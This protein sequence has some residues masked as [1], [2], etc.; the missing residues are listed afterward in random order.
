[1]PRPTNPRAKASPA[2]HPLTRAA[3]ISA[4]AAGA[5]FLEENAFA[6]D[7]QVYFS[8]SRDGKPAA[9]QRKPFAAY[10]LV[11]AL[12]E[13]A[14]A[15]GDDAMRERALGLFERVLGWIRTPG[16]LGRPVLDGSPA[17]DQLNVPMITLNV[18]MELAEFGDT[19]LSTF[20]PREQ[21]WA[22]AEI[23][24]HVI[25]DPASGCI[26]AVL[27]GVTPDGKADYSHVDGRVINPGH[28]IEAGWFLLAWAQAN[29]ATPLAEGTAGAAALP[30]PA[31]LEHAALEVMAWAFEF[32]W[33]SCNPDAE[34]KPAAAGGLL[35]F[36]DAEA[37]TP[38]Q[39]EHDMK[40]WWPANEAMIGC[41]MAYRLT[42]EAVWMERFDRV[43]SWA[44]G[45]LCDRTHGE[46]FGYCSRDGAVTHRFKGGAY[47]GCFHVPRCL[48]MCQRLLMPTTGDAAA[49]EVKKA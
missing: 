18:I 8:L 40:L 1:L 47:K 39:L 35:Y 44:Y 38:P 3:L 49:V 22:V 27:E 46:W 9:L 36:K 26:T 41:A 29:K 10:F 19:D 28:V 25:R 30:T 5:A 2:S 43:A 15:T 42:S 34:L 23:L 31:A 48:L 12:N 45:H 21:A 6:P 4:A 33:D 24:K 32:G 16:S 20:Y 7:G 13:V 37:W 17:L 11:M 14:R